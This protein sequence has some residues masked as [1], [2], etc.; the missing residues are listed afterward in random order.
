MLTITNTLV[1]VTML[2]LV[3]HAVEHVHHRYCAR[4]VVMQILLGDAAY[5]RLLSAAKTW[6]E[7][8]FR[9]TLAIQIKM[10]G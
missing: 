5:C 9:H 6:I 3:S 1:I 7:V 4:N 2:A 8:Q 10:L